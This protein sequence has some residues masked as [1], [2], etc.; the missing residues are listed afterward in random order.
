[1]VSTADGRATLQGRSGGLSSPADRALF[2]ALRAPVDAVLVGAGTVRTERYGRMIPDPERRARRRSRGLSEEPLACI[3][4]SRLMLDPAIPLLGDPESRVVVLTPAEGD[5]PAG[6]ACHVEYVRSATTDGMLD[7]H[8]ALEELARRFDVRVLLCEGGPHLACEL[9]AAGLLDELYL[10]VSPKLAGGEPAGM[11]GMRILA[12]AE[13]EPPAE[14]A[15]AGVSRSE[16]HLFLRYEVLAP[17]R[18]APDTTL[19]SSLAS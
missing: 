19:S 12:G 14:L 2:H 1:M 8:A 15:L 17:E 16:S 10:S 6:V 13:L 9:V 11:A 4:S 7:L 5:L 3:V 18:V